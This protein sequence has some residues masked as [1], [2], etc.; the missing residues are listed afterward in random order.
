[1]ILGI[2]SLSL[3]LRK[4][5]PAIGLLL[6]ICEFVRAI[7][8]SFLTRIAL[9]TVSKSRLVIAD[10]KEPKFPPSDSTSQEY[11]MDGFVRGPEDIREHT[12]P[13]AE[14]PPNR[15][16]DVK[17]G[18][19][20][21]HTSAFN[22]KVPNRNKELPQIKHPNPGQSK[23][24]IGGLP[25][26]G[27][28]FPPMRPQ[29]PILA[30]EVKGV[31]TLSKERSRVAKRRKQ[32]TG[33]AIPVISAPVLNNDS[34]NPLGKITTVDLENAA[35]I[36]RQRRE[37]HMKSRRSLSLNA[38]PSP[39]MMN[40]EQMMQRSRSVVHRKAVG[41]PTSHVTTKTHPE[42]VHELGSSS[43]T[44]SAMLSPRIDD[45]RRISPCQPQESFLRRTLPP[46]PPLKT[47]GTVTAMTVSDIRQ[48]QPDAWD[49]LSVAQEKGEVDPAIAPSDLPLRLHPP[50]DPAA[51]SIATMSW[52][53]QRGSAG[54]PRRKGS[55]SSRRSRTDD[56]I[57]TDPRAPPPIP[58]KCVDRKDSTPGQAL[59]T[60]P[61]PPYK[62][63]GT[64][65][66]PPKRAATEGPSPPNSSSMKVP[67][68]PPKPEPKFS[69]FPS[70]YSSKAFGGS[71]QQ[72]PSASPRE[73]LEM[74]LKSMEAPR[75]LLKNPKLASM[76]KKVFLLRNIEYNQPV[77]NSPPP[78]AVDKPLPKPP[79]W[80]VLGRES[81]LNRP[82][83]IPRTPETACLF[84]FPGG[85]QQQRSYIR[86]MSCSSVEPRKSILHIGAIG[87][88]SQLP[89]LPPI[90][91]NV[92]VRQLPNDTKS[93]T[94]EEK[95]DIFYP[96]SRRP[97]SSI[98]RTSRRRSTSMPDVSRTSP[99]S[100]PGVT[101]EE[102]ERQPEFRGSHL[103]NLYCSGN[104]TEGRT[105][106]ILSE[107][108]IEKRVRSIQQQVHNDASA[109]P[110]PIQPHS[111]EFHIEL[112]RPVGIAQTGLDGEGRNVDETPVQNGVDNNCADNL[113]INK[114]S[115]DSSR[116]DSPDIEKGTDHVLW[117]RSIG[118]ECPTFSH[119][120]GTVRSRR[121]PPPAPLLLN[122]PTKAIL[123]QAEPSPLDG[124]EHALG[125]IEEKL[126]TLERSSRT[127]SVA[128]EQRMTL[129]ADLEK[130][131]GLQE[132]R[133]Q[134]LRHT[135]IRDS[136]STVNISP[137][138]AHEMARQ[139]ASLW[140][141]IHES[142]GSKLFPETGE[143]SDHS[144][145]PT[146]T[147]RK[148]G[149]YETTSRKG[150]SH[151]SNA[152]NRMS[153][154]T[155][156]HP[157]TPQLGTPTPPDTD[158]SEAEEETEIPVVYFEATS[159]T[160]AV[161]S[162]RPSLWRVEAASPMIF[163]HTPSLWSP[164]TVAF[165]IAAELPNHRAQTLRPITKRALEPLEIESRHLW[166][167]DEAPQESQSRGLWDS[168]LHPSSPDINPSRKPKP[169]AQKPTRNT[170]RITSL[171]D[172]LESP[173]PLPD[174][175]DTL[176][177][178]QFPSGEK[179]DTVAIRPPMFKVAA[180]PGT[181]TTGR[182]IIHPVYP[183][184]IPNF[185]VD[186]QQSSF[187][188]YCD[189]EDVGDNFSESDSDGDNDD[190]DEFDETTL[191]EIASLLQPEKA[192]PRKSF[193][194]GE[195][196]RSGQRTSV[197]ASPT[198]SLDSPQH[199]AIPMVLDTKTLELPKPK[200][201][202]LWKSKSHFFQVE[203]SQGLPQPDK[204]TW[205]SYVDAVSRSTRSSKRNV[206]PT[207]ISSRDLW[208]APH[209]A[210]SSCPSLLWG[211]KQDPSRVKS[212]MAANPKDGDTS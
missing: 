35:R 6:L 2:R 92:M 122:H 179:S 27:H 58:Q 20:P 182:A 176:G 57:F 38:Q 101:Q 33:T 79:D 100:G 187:F 49:L 117:H 194:L 205:A 121:G 21:M 136:L 102:V 44:V 191:W 82:R 36:D 171:P 129:I 172:I 201:S 140:S 169:L 142:R 89:P 65:L 175:R 25:V 37:M 77:P 18:E 52:S 128:E 71:P 156:S 131:M 119:R 116:Y 88:P 183:V 166:T 110:G 91:S 95:M 8:V 111:E 5:L 165:S 161:Q 74:A 24:G 168:S 42:P 125:M 93:M 28:L 73:L 68:S 195:W 199:V 106:L 11:R 193:T 151:L 9:V 67:H 186:Q 146:S 1:M 103:S 53:S 207:F 40:P 64:V 59:G 115:R 190:D 164:T 188:D 32:E 202:S 81:V 15:H 60:Y 86:P 123:V 130:E 153:L 138:Q 66:P 181:I 7:A 210:N 162:P 96:E 39:S 84:N 31:P 55:K 149:L 50:I 51:K 61:P 157:T 4:T 97:F 192:A 75:P 112:P 180:I 170:K 154:L 63:D 78:V 196:K 114:E 208:V 90:P 189:E 16:I 134:K 212:I 85:I 197:V 26:T 118:Q 160:Q 62:L 104:D 34:S 126:R 108:N 107:S 178:F 209:V 145:S 159:T 200:S 132:T 41:Q 80:E 14:R 54:I 69:I 211:S 204:E 22:A 144:W 124:P 133:W 94:F 184:A 23:I 10:N 206:S 72:N 173:K 158:E 147:Q 99:K 177:I 152:R 48:P 19:P 70:G 174:K 150:I 203:K 127:S 12:G 141:K 3:F 185:E 137:Q 56:M 135:I 198:D 167:L 45:S 148:S 76:D 29:D 98:F 155:V 30:A 17:H 87:S 109:N 163:K 105:S 83:P 139:H 47:P 120:R 43:T 46:V 13:I 143:L 113:S